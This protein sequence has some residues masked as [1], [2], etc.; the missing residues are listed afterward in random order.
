MEC[1]PL[2]EKKEL[3]IKLRKLRKQSYEKG[4]IKEGKLIKNRVK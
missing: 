3:G 1:K 2:F 4:E